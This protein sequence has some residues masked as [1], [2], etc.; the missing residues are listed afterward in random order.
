MTRRT[1]ITVRAQRALGT[2]VLS[3][4]D[5]NWVMKKCYLTIGNLQGVRLKHLFIVTLTK[6]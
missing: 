1:Y 6:F 2:N 3:E 4:C 5:M